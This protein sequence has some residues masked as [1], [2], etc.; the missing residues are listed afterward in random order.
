MSQIDVVSVCDYISYQVLIIQ[1]S[2]VDCVIVIGITPDITFILRV[3][4]GILRHFPCN[5]VN[6]VAA[7]NN[8]VITYY[9]LNCMGTF[10]LLYVAVTVIT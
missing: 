10:G 3:V 5:L 1:I 4:C 7:Q 2:V 9:S 8:L 6:C